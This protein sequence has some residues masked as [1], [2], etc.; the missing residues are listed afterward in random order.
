MRSGICVVGARTR[1]L[2][3]GYHVGGPPLSVQLY[4]PGDIEGARGHFI[5]FQHS[6]YYVPAMALSPLVCTMLAPPY[7]LL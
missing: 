3:A 1:D 6:P 5:R 2:S 4:N 7:G